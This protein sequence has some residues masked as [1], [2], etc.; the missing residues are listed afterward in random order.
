MGLAVL[1]L[2][3]VAAAAAGPVA[4]VSGPAAAPSGLPHVL[5]INS[6][7]QGFSWT[8]EQDRGIRQA[9]LD[10]FGPWGVDISVF[11]LEARH[12]PSRTAQSIAYFH[13]LY[14]EA[15]IDLVVTTDNLA[16][17]FMKDSAWRIGRGIPLVFAGVNDFHD[18]GKLAGRLAT[19]V[20]ENFL[21]GRIDTLRAAAALLPNTRRFLFILDKSATS[22][23]IR[24]EI[25]DIMPGFPGMGFEYVVEENLEAQ[26]ALAARQTE[27]TVI[28]PIGIHTDAEGTVL[29]YESSMERLAESA[30]VPCFGFIE[31]RI[32]HGLAGGK[33]LTGYDHGYRAG[34]LGAEILAGRPVGAV[35]AILD[36]P[37]RLYFDWKV[38]QRFNLP[39]RSLPAGAVILNRP[40][41]PLE[42]YRTYVIFLTVFV[43]IML[44]ALVLMVFGRRNLKRTQKQLLQSEMVL[45][46][47]FDNS[48]NP[49]FVADD[50][51][52]YIR[53]NPSA[54][55]LTGYPAAQLLTKRVADLLTPESQAAG[56]RHFQGM[57]KDGRQYGELE[58]MRPDGR[59]YW[60]SVHAARIGGGQNLGIAQDITARIQADARLR[61]SLQE[62]ETLLR[63][64]YHRTKNNMYIMTSLL[65]LHEQDIKAPEDRLVFREMAS[66][67]QTMALVHEKLYSSESLS[68][69]KFDGY[70]KDLAEMLA[71]SY[72]KPGISF[73]FVF[74]P[75]QMVLEM[76]MPLGLVLNELLM[77]SMRHAFADRDEGRINI[78]MELAEG[79]T[80][81]L[82]VGDDGAGFPPGFDPAT[83]P[84]MGMQT[85]NS[86]VEYQ[87]RG[88]VGWNSRQGVSC[89]L[90][91]PLPDASGS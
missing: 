86:I 9:L 59:R 82:S 61:Q 16:W 24:N 66:R 45:A 34:Q 73:T 27:G 36:N 28:V 91:I 30:G 33:I 83:A 64:L 20:A 12:F 84:S 47:Y 38:L 31:N 87:L 13:T 60:M 3:A 52:R 37:G 18:D 57:M 74:H 50:E 69:I 39:E 68:H 46:S 44:V 35:P 63:E 62:K 75:V 55:E 40:V 5:V 32:G 70:I 25:E 53:V 88:K 56:L 67:I 89:I 17:D 43:L 65:A 21:S 49:I 81:V 90:T 14:A 51:G 26:R 79:P 76:A 80:L 4:A 15:G 23:A 1:A 48:P 22:Q 29:P 72:G 8:D 85:I 2:A 10:R 78:S 7:H 58:F 71:K 54:A 41:G 42:E 11:N 6:Y 77:N 19:G